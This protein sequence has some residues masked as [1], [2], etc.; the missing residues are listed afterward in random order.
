MYFKMGASV[1]IMFDV[2]YA[3]II[4]LFRKSGA[5]FDQLLNRNN[6]PSCFFPIAMK[7]LNATKYRAKGRI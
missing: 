6:T 4:Q 1:C 3:S 5:I 7:S 2:L